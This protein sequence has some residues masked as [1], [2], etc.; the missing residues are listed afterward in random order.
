MRLKTTEDSIKLSWNPDKKVEG[1]N[2]YH[3]TG[4][5]PWLVD[6]GKLASVKT[7]NFIHKDPEKNKIHYY[8][9]TSVDSN[10]ESLPSLKVRSQ[11]RIVKDIVVSPLS[12][13][14]V[15]IEWK[16]EDE[17]VAGFNVYRAERGLLNKILKWAEYAREPTIENRPGLTFPFKLVNK[18]LIK[19]TKFTDN[20]LLKKVYAYRVSAVN[21]LGIESG[22]SPYIL[23]IPSPPQYLFSKEDGADCQLKWQKNPEKSVVGYNIYRTRKDKF[24]DNHDLLNR[25]PIKLT[26]FTDI[27]ATK[28]MPRKPANTGRRY[29]VTAVDF[30]GQ[31]SFPSA[32]VWF[33]REWR[34]F[35]KI[36]VWHQ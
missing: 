15:E 24:D 7:N 3:G 35:Y 12:E 31:E 27:N 25:E 5:K 22:P 13:N 10:K 14:K 26:R 1:Y 30:L 20:I 16:T 18:K 23:T 17:D 28:G 32:P 29:Y 2:V 6:Y 19:D 36:E 34:K 4:E 8:Y 9:V 11:P 33:Y 21:N